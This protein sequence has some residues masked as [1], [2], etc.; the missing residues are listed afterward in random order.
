MNRPKNLR[1]SHNVRIDEKGR[2]KIP[3]DYRNYILEGMNYGNL[4]FVT[5]DTGES[6]QIY[7]LVIWEEIEARLNDYGVMD[8]TVEMFITMTSYWGHEAEMDSQGRILIHPELR[9]KT[10]LNGEVK[11]M[12]KINHMVIWPID[13]IEDRVDKYTYSESDR[14]KIHG[15]IS[16]KPQMIPSKSDSTQGQP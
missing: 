12:G 8:S 2:I 6:V 1:G 11:I 15:I 14:A 16:G 13:R 9:A 10:K 7:P 5:S 4:F 3:A